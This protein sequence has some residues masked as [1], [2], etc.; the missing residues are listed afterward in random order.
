MRSAVRLFAVLTAIA[1]AAI[2]GAGPTQ[3]DPPPLIEPIIWQLNRDYP[4]GSPADSTLEISTVYIKTHDGSDW[5]STYD[6]H[7]LAVSGPASIQNLIN[8]YDAQGIDV[9]AWFVPKGTDYDRQ[10]EM[11]IRVI[12]SGVTALY[13]D[14]EPFAGFCNQNCALLA[15]NF[16]SRVRAERPDARLG[17]IYDPRTQYWGPSATPQWFA[18]ATVAMPMCY[19][20]TF[21]G[22]G[23]F[24]DP[25]GCVTQ[26]KA[27]LAILSPNRPMEYLPIL[28]GDSTPERTEQALD[29]AI[30]SG[31][32]RVSLWRRGVVSNDVWSMIDNYQAPSGPHCAE[33]LI[34]G[35]II[36]DVNSGVVSIV[37]GGARFGFPSW[38][39]FVTMGFVA[40][41]IQ[42]MANGV[43]DALP[44]APRDGTVIQEFGSDSRYIVIGG[45][46]FPLTGEQ[47]A[48][49]DAVA[50]IPPQTAAQVPSTPADYTRIREED[51]DDIF[52]VVRGERVQLDDTGEQA[53]T[54]LGIAP[55][56]LIVPD[57]SLADLPVMNVPRGDVDCSGQIG[58]PDVLGM[59]RKTIGVANPSACISV[60]GDVTCD[61][62]TLPVDAL[63]VLLHQAEAPAVTS[64]EN[65]PPIG[66]PHPALLS[67]VTGVPEVTL[68]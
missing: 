37:R 63:L 13:A 33:N 25:A 6:Q 32:T 49:G 21:A 50:V 20:E 56:L 27:D 43:I 45:V 58:A 24:G 4:E 55:H 26:A 54:D 19:W 65:C 46:K 66:E 28:Q 30:R 18:N 5:M 12:D 10:V 67:T 59:I 17:V 22:Q 68:E 11:A 14:L 48:G 39:S 8:V 15:A 42:V 35:C 38:D 53:L 64:A 16:W 7:P 34:D 36:R 57:G 29:A 23:I 51:S 31:A 1:L 9:A 62:L 44:Y 60:S 3:A 61:G 41:D 40:R 52:F 2:L 47:L